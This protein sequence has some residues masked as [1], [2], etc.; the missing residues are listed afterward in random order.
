M[1]LRRL[2]PG[3][4]VDRVDTSPQARARLAFRGMATGAVLVPSPSADEPGEAEAAFPGG[5]Q[6]DRIDRIDS[7]S[8]RS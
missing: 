1:K 6:Q 4:Q 7:P 3:A 5:A 8:S 2:L